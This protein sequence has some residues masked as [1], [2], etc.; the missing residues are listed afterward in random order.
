M[1]NATSEKRLALMSASDKRG[2]VEFAELL[3]ECGFEIAS[4]G[5]TASTLRAAGVAVTEVSELTGAAEL[6][7]GRVKTLH[8]RIHGG[9]LGLRDDAG[10]VQEMAAHGIRP[11]DV[12][13]N[14]LYPFVET[15]RGGDA[16]LSDALENIDIGGPAMTR[17]AAKNHPHVV[18]VVDPADYA[19]VGEMIRGGGV[20][21]SVRRRLAAKAFQ[22]VAAYDTAIAEYLRN[23]G[24]GDGDGDLGGDAAAGGLPSELTFGYAL[25]ATPRY[26]ENPHQSAGIYSAPG[27]TGGIVNAEQLHGIPMS[28]LNYF[29]ADAAWS[30]AQSFGDLYQGGEGRHVAVVVKHANPC[31]LAVRETQAA[32]WDAARAGD[33]VSAFGGIVA[34]DQPLETATAE[35]MAGLLL[36]VIVAPGYEDG[37]LEILRRRRRTRVLQVQPHRLLRWEVR[38]VSG[39]ALVQAP[40]RFEAETAA[41]FRVVTARQPTD[42]ERL[43][44]EFAWRAGRFVKS[45]A[46]VLARDRQLVGMGAGQPNRVT[47]VRLAARVAGDAAAGSAMASDAFIPFPDA[48]EVGAEAG[49]RAVVQ[50][51][52]SVNDDAVIAAADELGVAMLFTSRRHFYH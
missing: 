41:D 15:V 50:P 13:V 52:G 2:L 40:D 51:G 29:D 42:A 27:E 46:I 7:D 5:G 30:V 14:N 18:V 31:G 39:G 11:I 24:G 26:G 4:T 43:D 38:S 36:D 47:S 23:G 49:V 12:V 3:A 17:A 34:F 22:H 6:M 45:N 16:S 9:L 48:V 1:A 10:H 20:S 33:P 44:L 28:Y 21:Q 32:A 35:R 8:P 19:S 25:R 37:A